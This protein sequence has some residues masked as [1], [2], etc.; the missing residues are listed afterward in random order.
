MTLLARYI[1]SENIKASMFIRSRPSPLPLD[2]PEP[3]LH[4]TLS[5][6]SATKSTSLNGLL[7]ELQNADKKD[8]TPHSSNTSTQVVHSSFEYM[9]LKRT[10]QLRAQASQTRLVD[11]LA[12]SISAAE[13]AHPLGHSS[14][15]LSS[16]P[17]RS[18]ESNPDD[19]HLSDFFDEASSKHKHNIVKTV[20]SSW[21]QLPGFTTDLFQGMI[22]SEYTQLTPV[23]AVV[24]ML[25]VHGY[26]VICSAPTG[27][28]KTLAFLI[29]LIIHIQRVRLM[30]PDDP[31]L[32]STCYALVLTPTRELAM[33]IHSVL[34]EIIG[35]SSI[36][37]TT[38]LLIGGYTPT[39][40]HPNVIVGV[41]GKVEHF[42]LGYSSHKYTLRKCSYIVLDELD[43]LL[44][45]GFIE[46]VSTILKVC[47]RDKQIVGTTATLSKQAHKVIEDAGL[48]SRDCLR[49]TF[50]CAMTGSVLQ[51]NV[52][53]A[54]L[55]V[56]FNPSLSGNQSSVSVAVP[57]P[58][59]PDPST[60]PSKQEILAS[61]LQTHYSA[62]P[63]SQTIIFLASKENVDSLL[64]YLL[65]SKSTDS[66]SALYHCE[67]AAFHSGQEQQKRTTVVSRFR[68]N[69]IQILITTSG[70][71][72]GLDFPSV[73]MIINYDIPRCAEYYVHQ[74]GRTAR[75]M[76]TGTALTLVDLS[77]DIKYLAELAV[78]VAGVRKRLSKDATYKTNGMSLPPSFNQK[79][80]T[81]RLSLCIR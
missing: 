59:L 14:I 2:T 78:R 73:C 29:P 49:K 45:A 44:D 33:Q 41:P 23:Q 27:S 6:E 10:A 9:D 62:R 3:Q 30:W 67:V 58:L 37:L 46:Q 8:N 54:Q 55:F 70:G 4:R 66:Y 7:Q 77:N 20:I 50:K 74:I 1:T 63:T 32:Q 24:P 57:N 39:E 47:A 38:S 42:V 25:L 13:E 81:L 21:N 17:D 5:I 51:P 40:M 36:S 26:N 60:Y 15:S 56:E 71:G 65:K 22:R 76:A 34:L 48:I 68:A 52:R 35:Q 61:I 53:I 11:R 12:A 79:R 28:G 69:Q 31:S 43:E 18:N 64:E 16:V 19:F 72:R 75:G 80:K